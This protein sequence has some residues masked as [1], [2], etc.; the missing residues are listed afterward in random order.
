VRFGR[1]W[2]AETGQ[3][4]DPGHGPKKAGAGIGRIK[5]GSRLG[6]LLTYWLHYRTAIMP[7][8]TCVLTRIVVVSLPA[9]GCFCF[10]YAARR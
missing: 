4:V 2:E 7:A 10:A 8:L 6:L 9:I 5:V 3:G 1:G